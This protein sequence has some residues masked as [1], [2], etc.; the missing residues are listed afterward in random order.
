MFAM[1]LKRLCFLLPNTM[2]LAVFV[3]RCCHALEAVQSEARTLNVPLTLYESMK[4]DDVVITRIQIQRYRSLSYNNL[5]Y[6]HHRLLD[7]S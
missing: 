4:R 6:N 3:V 7:F 2:P 5:Y 1:I